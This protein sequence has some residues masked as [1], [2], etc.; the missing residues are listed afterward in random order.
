MDAGLDLL[1][2]ADGARAFSVRGVCLSSGLASRYFYESFDNSG[3]LAKA[4]YDQEVLDLTTVTLAAMDGVPPDDLPLVARTA[5]GAVIG[6][7]ADDP[8]RGRLLFSPALVALPAIAERRHASTRLF[9]GLFRDELRSRV[10][11][12]D[13]LSLEV[14]AETMI[15]GLG[16]SVIAWLDKE[17]TLTVEELVTAYSDVLSLVALSFVD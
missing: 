12:A 9:V 10:P 7:V 3:E 4:I 5:I 13:R 6:L 11:A 1:A 16:Q 17:I 15:G 14:A 2:S 8:R